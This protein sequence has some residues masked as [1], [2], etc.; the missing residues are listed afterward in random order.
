RFRRNSRRNC[1]I[2]PP[3]A[4]QRRQ[5]IARVA[6]SVTPDQEPVLLAVA[7]HQ[8]RVAVLMRGTAHGAVTAI[9]FPTQ[10]LR[11]AGGLAHSKPSDLAMR[12]ASSRASPRASRM[13]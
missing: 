10:G 4:A 5:D 6:P 2:E 7:Q 13:A 9:P 1:L 11:D 12:S 3:I 8:R